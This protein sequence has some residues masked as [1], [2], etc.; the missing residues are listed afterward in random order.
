MYDT[1]ENAHAKLAGTVFMFDGRPVNCLGAFDSGDNRDQI[2]LNLQFLPKMRDN[3]AV[4]INDPRI[5]VRNLPLGYVNI[6]NDAIYLTRTPCRQF[7]QGLT[8]NSVVCPQIRRHGV[9]VYNFK[10]LMQRPEF[11]D[12]MMGVYPTFKE[13]VDMLLNSNEKLSVAFNRRFALAHDKDLGFFELRYKGNRVA[14]GDPNNFN[15]PSEFSYLT[16]VIHE[17]GI[18]VR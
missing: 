14:W 16:E 9:P 3:V 2:H 10:T 5:E 11:T 15:L 6:F 4:S 12:S 1:V 13:A 17:Q 7:R 8:S 18:S